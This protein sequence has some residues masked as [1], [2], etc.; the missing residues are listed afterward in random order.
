MRVEMANRLS[1][2]ISPRRH[3]ERLRIRAAGMAPA[4]RASRPDLVP[5]LKGDAPG[6]RSRVRF[7]SVLLVAQIAVCQFLLAGAALLTR[8]YF[9]M[10]RINPGFDTSRKLLLAFLVPGDMTRGFDY[11][12]LAE[13]MAAVPGVR[14]AT[15]ARTTPF[16][17]A[18]RGGMELRGPRLFRRH[19]RPPA[20]RPGF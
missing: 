10:Q 3:G 9:E 7:R 13:K 17:R 16:P 18:A 14:R 6:G 8:S 5:A 2:K 19:R 12:Q 20:S 15:Y 4:L 11:R 1:P